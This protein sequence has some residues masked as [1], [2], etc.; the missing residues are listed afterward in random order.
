[1]GHTALRS[2]SSQEKESS[3]G[4]RKFDKKLQFYAKVKDTVASLHAKKEIG[5]K[6]KLNRR[7]RK[8]KAYDLTSLNEFLP[9]L[10]DPGQQCEEKNLKLKNKTRQ[11]LVEKEG[12]Q[13]KA[14]LSNPVFQLDPLAAI[15]Q[16]LERTQPICPV[17]KSKKKLS[18]TGRKKG[19]KLK[20]FS[21]AQDM[22][23]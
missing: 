14:V 10:K 9:E 1:M 22:D 16:H 4:M 8:L 19:K 23:V 11:K 2:G 6:K 20:T 15:H 17:E 13:L 3:K 12:K 5:K 18:K 21:A 7:Q